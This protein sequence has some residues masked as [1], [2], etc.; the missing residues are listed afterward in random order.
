MFLLGWLGSCAPTWLPCELPLAAMCS[1]DWFGQPFVARADGVCTL[2]D[3][4]A[5]EWNGQPVSHHCEVCPCGAFTRVRCANGYH[6]RT[7]WFDDGV[8]IAGMAYSDGGTFCTA[9]S[10]SQSAIYGEPPDCAVDEDSCVPPLPMIDALSARCVGD[11][12]EVD[13]VTHVPA[14][15]VLVLLATGIDPAEHAEDH[16]HRDGT[17]LWLVDAHDFRCEDLEEITIVARAY[18][19]DGRFRDCLVRAGR[20]AGRSGDRAIRR[21]VGGRAVPGGGRRARE[22]PALRCA[23]WQTALTPTDLSNSRPP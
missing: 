18:G 20:G 3:T 9:E 16:V 21:P 11:G 12:I 4:L 15:Q 1:D 17:A 23:A 6:G 8:L 22:L 10:R 5:S 2:E 13:A 7:G 19:T 14:E